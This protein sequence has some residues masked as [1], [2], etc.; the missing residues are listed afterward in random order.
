MVSNTTPMV[1]DMTRSATAPKT[2]CRAAAP[3][4]QGSKHRAAVC[5][6]GQARRAGP[7]RLLDQRDRQ[8]KRHQPAARDRQRKR[9]LG[10]APVVHGHAIGKG[11]Q[12]QGLRAPS[13]LSQGAVPT[14]P[15]QLRQQAH[16]LDA[17]GF[18]SNVTAERSGERGGGARPV[19]VLVQRQ[20]LCVGRGV[21][22]V[23]LDEPAH[24]H[25]RE[26]EHKQ[27]LQVV[28]GPLRATASLGW[29]RRSRPGC[30]R[31]THV[32]RNRAPQSA[33]P[34]AARSV[35][36]RSDSQELGPSLARHGAR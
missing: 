18:I 9:L 6:G 10:H 21:H 1:L 23:V 2:A 7:A 3:G 19:P 24:R 25:D 29:E 33:L 28:E 31:I 17:I 27:Q 22:D 11:E 13:A 32:T 20:V 5:P 14:L 35:A 12:E 26:V 36:P 15:R 16:T 8:R 34:G 4:N 30:K